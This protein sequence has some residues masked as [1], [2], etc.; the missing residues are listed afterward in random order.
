MR[1]AVI[2]NAPTRPHE[3]SRSSSSGAE[4]SGIVNQ[5]WS[6]SE[7]GIVGQ[8]RLVADSL[9]HAGHECLVLAADDVAE[10]SAL[11]ESATPD[12]I[13]NCCESFRGRSD[14]EMHL[15]A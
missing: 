15:A 9:K 13:F 3:E 5:Q 4:S 7:A 2:H 6:V 11:L 1:V 12:A 8:V 10:L 14:R